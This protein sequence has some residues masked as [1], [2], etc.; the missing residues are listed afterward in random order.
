MSAKSAGKMLLR[1]MVRG[2]LLL[3]IAAVVGGGLVATVHELTAERILVNERAALLSNLDALVPADRRDNNP[4][5]DTMEVVS[6]N[7]LGSNKPLTVYR[8]RRKGRTVAIILTAIA[9]NGY[10]G[11]IKLLV[12]VNSDGSLAGVRVINHHET[13]GLGDKIELEKSHWILGFNGK[14]LHNPQRTGWAVRKDGGAFD[15]F[16]GATITPRAVVRA[17]YNALKF[18]HDHSK[19]LLAAPPAAAPDGADAPDAP[20]TPGNP[21]H[22]TDGEHHD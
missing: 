3:T 7:F 8:A 21:P 17:V 4:L 20:T 13:P 14:S 6:A 15:Q 11:A 10:S 18:F 12:G 2:A 22:A 1:S 9:P 19:Q 16:T 5:N